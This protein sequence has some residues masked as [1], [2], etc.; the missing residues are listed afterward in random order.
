MTDSD[1]INLKFDN[2]QDGGEEQCQPGHRR[3]RRDGFL[4]QQRP[5]AE[6][7]Y[8]GDFHHIWSHRSNYHCCN[9]QDQVRGY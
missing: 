7:V 2:F 9:Y 6:E 3:D 1:R 8:L 5:E 4:H